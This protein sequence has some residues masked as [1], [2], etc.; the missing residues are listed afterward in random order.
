MARGVGVPAAISQHAQGRSPTPALSLFFDPVLSLSK[1]GLGISGPPFGKLSA[2]A[3]LI[4]A[5]S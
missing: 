5:S 4:F 1:H 3:V 2:G